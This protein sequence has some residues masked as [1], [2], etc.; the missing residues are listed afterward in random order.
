MKLAGYVVGILLSTY[1]QRKYAWWNI[2]LQ[3]RR[4]RIFP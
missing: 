2:L 3:F 4:Y 1:R